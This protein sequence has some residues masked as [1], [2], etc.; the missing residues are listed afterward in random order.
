MGLREKTAREGHNRQDPQRPS[1]RPPHKSRRET[2]ALRPP[3]DH[4]PAAQEI[5]TLQHDRKKESNGWCAYGCGGQS[6]GDGEKQ[7]QAIFVVG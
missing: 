1:E 5:E 4:P 7:V 6:G 2:N 3:S